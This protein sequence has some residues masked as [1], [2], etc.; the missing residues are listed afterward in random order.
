[1]KKTIDDQLS[2]IEVVIDKRIS[3]FNLDEHFTDEV[4]ATILSKLLRFLSS[5]PDKKTLSII[6]KLEKKVTQ[7]EK[8][9]SKA[10]KEGGI[11]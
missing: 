8:I 10:L 9:A 11:R 1:M 6:M 7:L 5:N 4:F 3:N 2:E